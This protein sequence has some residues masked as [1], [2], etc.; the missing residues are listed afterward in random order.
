MRLC[1]QLTVNIEDQPLVDEAKKIGISVFRGMRIILQ[2]VI[3]AA[4]SSV[5]DV[6]VEIT[7]DCP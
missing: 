4:E 7:G 5:A 6:I 2:R 3:G 1:L